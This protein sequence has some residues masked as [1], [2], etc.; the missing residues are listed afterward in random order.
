MRM[1]PLVSSNNFFE[2]TFKKLKADEISLRYADFD[3][4]DT[5]QIISKILDLSETKDI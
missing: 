3:A 1:T 4:T 5:N 2:G